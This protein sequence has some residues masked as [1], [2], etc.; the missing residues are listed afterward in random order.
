MGGVIDAGRTKEVRTILVEMFSQKIFL[1]VAKVAALK[2]CMFRSV[3]LDIYPEEPI[4]VRPNSSL[5]NPRSAFHCIFQLS[6][7]PSPGSPLAP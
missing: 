3:I 1:K 5:R 7:L 2:K 4:R 6:M